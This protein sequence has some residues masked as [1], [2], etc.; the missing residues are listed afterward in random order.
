LGPL[1]RK[2]TLGYGTRRVGAALPRDEAEAV[3]EY[4]WQITAL[5]GSGEH[6]LR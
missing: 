5:R 4:L 6:A 1:G 2:L 3:G